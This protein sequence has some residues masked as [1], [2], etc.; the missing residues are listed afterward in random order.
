VRY[1]EAWVLK[2][3]V[4]PRVFEGKGKHKNSR[5]VGLRPLGVGE[6]R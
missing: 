1:K 5:V 2:Q 4:V 3:G 6:S